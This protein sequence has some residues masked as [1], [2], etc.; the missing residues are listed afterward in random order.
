VVKTNAIPMNY[1]DFH[2]HSNRSNSSI[3]SVRSFL[4]DEFINNKNPTYHCS[5][6][7]H[8]WQSTNDDFEA[9]LSQLELISTEPNVI[10]IGEIGLDRLRG[11][12]LPTQIELFKK[13]VEIAENIH[14]PVVIHCV[15]SFSEIQ[16][17]RKQLNPTT[18]WAIHNFMGN[19]QIAQSLVKQGFYLSFCIAFAKNP[20]IA[21]A[22]I[23]TPVDRIF[24]ETD[25]FIENVEDVY[26]AAAKCLQMEMKELKVQIEKNFKAFFGTTPQ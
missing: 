6:G 4:V 24:F 2:N 1:I 10:A 9:M 7:I 5:V 23:S 22:L 26:I 15:R 3:V 13:Q 16:A 19:V 20:K 14:K 8:P 18:L 11:A 25:D 17:L 21:E 12:N